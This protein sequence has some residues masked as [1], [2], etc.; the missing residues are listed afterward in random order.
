MLL[1]LNTKNERNEEKLETEESKH[2]E[3]SVS[4]QKGFNLPSL[5]FFEAYCRRCTGSFLSIMNDTSYIDCLEISLRKTSSGLQ[6]SH[7]MKTVFKLVLDFSFF[8][9]ISYYQ[10]LSDNY[11][12]LFFF[13]DFIE[14]WLLLISTIQLLWLPCPETQLVIPSVNYFNS[15]IIKATPLIHKADSCSCVLPAKLVK[16]EVLNAVWR[17]SFAPSIIFFDSQPPNLQ[18]TL[19]SICTVFCPFKLKQCLA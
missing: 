9:A 1:Q 14:L 11:T 3:G 18:S 2:F 5:G 19:S 13:C 17:S 6:D 12:E 10:F 16:A 4:S 8:P 7:R 15:C